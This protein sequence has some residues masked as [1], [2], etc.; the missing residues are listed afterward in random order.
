MIPDILDKISL[1]LDLEVREAEALITSMIKGNLDD[2]QSAAALMGLRTKGES[3]QEIASFVNVLQSHAVPVQIQNNR[4]VDLCGTG[5]DRTGTFNISTAAM[6]IVAGANIPVVKHGNRSIS[7]KSGSADVLEA[8]G[9]QIDT[10]PEQSAEIF[11]QIGLVFLFAPLYH[12]LL[13]QIGGVRKRLGVRTIFNLLGPLLNPAR[14][15][16]QVIG[17][18]GKEAAH[19]IQRTASLLDM[20]VLLTVHA[21][22]G[23]DEISLSAPTWL[24][25]FRDGILSDEPVF[26][27]PSEMRL[28]MYTLDEIQGGDAYENAEIIRSILDNQATAAQRDIALI[29]AAFGIMAGSDGVLLTEAYE[30]AKESLFSGAAKSKLSALIQS[31]HTG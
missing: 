26:F 16:R 30:M 22:D 23:L 7:S 29:N 2:V 21:T 27:N 31:S 19:K 12:P 28:P 15:K 11:D 1:G 3:M 25:E 18:Y 8:L 9:V 14:V 10:T 6:F 20:D 5:G 13:K 24:F 4:A 17:V